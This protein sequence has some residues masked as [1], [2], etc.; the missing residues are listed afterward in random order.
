M[1]TDFLPLLSNSLVSSLQSFTSRDV[2]SG[3]PQLPGM[4]TARLRKSRRVPSCI[5]NTLKACPVVT[6]KTPVPTPNVRQMFLPF[7]SFEC[8]SLSA[9]FFRLLPLASLFVY[10]LV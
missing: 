3:L 8:I 10:V 5:P 4:Y 9:D 7:S 6:G 1:T 2:G